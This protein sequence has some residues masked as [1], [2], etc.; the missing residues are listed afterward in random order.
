MKHY[1]LSC[2][3]ELK[4]E[5]LLCPKCGHCSLLDA[6]KESDKGIAGILTAQQIEANTQ[7]VKYKCGRDGLS[8]HGFAAEDANAMN[9]M[10]QEKH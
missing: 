5:Q 8:G 9:D 10:W 7:W 4:E 3:T 1:C 6:F 2:G